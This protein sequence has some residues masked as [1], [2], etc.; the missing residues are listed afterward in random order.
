MNTKVLLLTPPF[1]QLNTPYPATMY[2]KGFLN[3]YG[4]E[5]FQMD[6]GLD[7]IL[8]LLSKDTLI[9]LF[10]EVEQS[11][12]EISDNSFRILNLKEEYLACITPVIRFLQNKNSSLAYSIAEQN[13]LPQASRFEQLSDLEWAFGAIGVQD[14][15]KYL[16]TLFLQDLADFIRETLDP[17]FGFNR[18]AERLGLTATTFDEL[19][20]QLAEEP[21]FVDDILFEVLEPK[22]KEFQPKK[23]NRV[24]P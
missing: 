19:Y 3:Q 9:K 14:K 8:K 20:A 15:A 12:L 24:L 4:I 11:D 23:L 7:V 17:F 21:T 18:Y 16:A 22:V 13:F 2:L 10:H 6:L 5:T 1:T